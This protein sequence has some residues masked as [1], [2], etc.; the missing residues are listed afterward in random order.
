MEGKS[1][2]SDIQRVRYIL[3]N[4]KNPDFIFRQELFKTRKD[5]EEV[6]NSSAY[7]LKFSDYFEIEEIRF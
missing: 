2:N 7:G 5:A 1:K 6:L 4:R 3:V